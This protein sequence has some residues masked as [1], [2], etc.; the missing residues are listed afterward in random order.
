MSDQASTAAASDAPNARPETP[1]LD[2]SVRAVG[3]AGR[4]T[5]GSAKDTSRALRRLVS[6]DLQLARSAFGRGLAWACVA[7]VFGASSWLLLAGAIIALLQ[8]AGLSWFQAMFF[9]AL[10]SLLVTGIAAWR[11]FFYFDHTGLNATRRQLVKLGIF[12]DSSDDDDAHA[13]AANGAR[14]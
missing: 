11:V 14:T 13:S 3:A 12:D 2:E 10:A 7:V 6:A 5:L 8:R 9:T 1:G 4:A